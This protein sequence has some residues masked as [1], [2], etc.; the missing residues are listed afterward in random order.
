MNRI[1]KKASIYTLYFTVLAYIF[2]VLFS[3]TS[4]SSDDNQDSTIVTIPDANFEQALIDLGFDTNGFNGNILK[5]DAEQVTL[6]DVFDRNISSLQGIG[7]FVNLVRL[8]CDNNQ[9][10]SLDLSNNLDLKA[11][12]CY[13]NQL[14][15]LNVTNNLA[16]TILSCENNQLTN[17][18]LGN[19]LALEEFGCSNNN[20]I[21]SLDLEANIALT[22]LNCS[23]NNQLKNLSVKNGNNINVIF[24][25]ALENPNLTCIEVDDVEHSTNNWTLI[26]A[27]TTYSND[28]N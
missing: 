23:N 21:K 1:I 6:L 16:L 2:L 10:T 12:D 5:T 24:F 17:L 13:N 7:G 3:L 26:D 8:H 20:N 4:C 11:L 9:I 19:N 27:T 25:K 15:S 22:L 28:C 18:D 14:S